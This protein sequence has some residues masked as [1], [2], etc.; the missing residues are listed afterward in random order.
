MIRR[1]GSSSYRGQRP[2]RKALLLS[3][4]SSGPSSTLRPHGIVQLSPVPLS[5]ILLYPDSCSL[6]EPSD[7]RAH[8][9][10]R[11]FALNV[12]FCPDG[13]PSRD[14]HGSL[15][16]NSHLC[17]GIPSSDTMSHIYVTLS[18]HP[19]LFFFFS[20]CHQLTGYV[21]ICF[22]T[23]WLPHPLECKLQEV[24][25][26]GVSCHVLSTHHQACLC[27]VLSKY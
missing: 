14:V 1:G 12:A 10:P 18:P 22:S 7:R 20:P 17:S 16:V 9:Y 24:G 13:L 4:P 26:F 3:T 8:F 6:L 23:V 21:L 15:L 2:D 19:V 11:A 5:V 25:D 27:C